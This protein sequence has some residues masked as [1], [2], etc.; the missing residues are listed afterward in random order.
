MLMLLE[1][2]ETVVSSQFLF[3]AAVFAAN[4]IGLAA[5]HY[6]IEKLDIAG[7]LRKVGTW[8]EMSLLASSSAI[9]SLA[10]LEKYPQPFWFAM[11]ISWGMGLVFR[12]LIPE[13]ASVAL[14]KFRALLDLMF[15]KK[16]RK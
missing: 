9:V 10:V 14:E 2:C 7:A 1:E 4:I 15:G 16:E 12:P 11:T 6:T 8:I 13:L 5:A 3:A